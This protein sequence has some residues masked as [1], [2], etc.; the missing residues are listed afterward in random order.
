MSI[1]KSRVGLV[2]IKLRIEHD[3]WY[4]MRYNEKWRDVSF[5]GGHQKDRDHENLE[6]TAKRELWEEVPAIRAGL[7]STLIPLVGPLNYG[8]VH[9]RSRGDL[10]EYEVAFFLLKIESN[11]SQMLERLGSRTKNLLV[12]ESEL[13]GAARFPISGYVALLRD[14]LDDGLRSIAFSNDADLANRP[15]GRSAIDQ[16]EFSLRH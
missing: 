8:P 16:Y 13:L 12:S 14:S 9:S 11:P 5:I 1:R 15:I 10:A 4:L 6:R 7:I 3:P 2:V